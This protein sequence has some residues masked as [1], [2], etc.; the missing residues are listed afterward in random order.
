M[1]I[2]NLKVNR[3]QRGSV[4]AEYVIAAVGIGLAIIVA[5]SALG[6]ELKDR[7]TKSRDLLNT[8]VTAHQST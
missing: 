1:N 4:A 2:K 6:E 3:K 5:A 7:Y 8:Y